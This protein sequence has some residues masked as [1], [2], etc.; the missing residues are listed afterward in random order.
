MKKTL[1]IIATM[2]TMSVTQSNAQSFLDVLKGLGSSSKSEQTETEKSSSSSASNLLSGLGNIVS[3]LLGT[4]KVSENSLMGTWSYKQPAIVFESENVLANV[5][6]MAAGKAAEQKLQTYLN[7]I[8]FTEGKVKMTFNEDGT[9]KVTYANKDI[10]F[11]WSASD[12]DLTIKLGSST[13][14]ALASSSKLGKYT[15]F[16]MNCKVSLN[17]IQL[18]FKADKLLS[19]VSKIVSAAG[20]ATNNSTISSITS[21]AN[22]VDGMY[23]GLTLEK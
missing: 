21:L 18:S 8:G 7:K 1:F 13:I 14:S 10:P 9:G 5:G 11:Q 16:K 19:F 3:G 15:S 6:G 2:L 17:S 12:S 4:D 23:L 22:K 20:K